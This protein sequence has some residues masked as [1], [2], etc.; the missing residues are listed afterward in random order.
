MH[1]ERDE[2]FRAFAARVRGKAE[3]CEFKAMCQC[4]NDVNY[5]DHAIRDVLLSGISDL[6]IR[7]EVLGTQAILQKPVNDVSLSL[8]AKRWRVTPS[9]HRACQPS[10]HSEANRKC[11]RRRIRQHPH[12]R[13]AQDKHR[14]QTARS[15]TTSSLRALK[16]GTSS[17]TRSA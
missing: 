9:P 11:R 14:A 12:H 5:T 13:I 2:P 10:R 6:D 17:L 1:Q 4:G 3:T 7:R 16:D 8:K 15:P